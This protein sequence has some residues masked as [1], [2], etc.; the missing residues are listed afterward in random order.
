MTQRSE[1]TGLPGRRSLSPAVFKRG[2]RT[3]KLQPRTSTLLSSIAAFGFVIGCFG[4]M[5]L[6]L[7][8]IAAFAWGP[9][10]RPLFYGMS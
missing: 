8:D 9:W 5:V 1:L 2:R 4:F 10:M 3:L 7:W 6:A